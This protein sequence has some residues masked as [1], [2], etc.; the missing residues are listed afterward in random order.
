MEDK[1]KLAR[2]WLKSTM[3]LCV[4]N[5]LVICSQEKALEAQNAVELL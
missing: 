2:F 1:C 4:C 3:K 5:K